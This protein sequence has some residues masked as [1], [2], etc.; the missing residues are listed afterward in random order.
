MYMLEYE[1]PY[2]AYPDFESSATKYVGAVM[3]GL[4]SGGR[5]CLGKHFL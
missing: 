5:A 1:G 3:E 4:C 2:H